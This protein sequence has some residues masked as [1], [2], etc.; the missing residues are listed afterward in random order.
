MATLSPVLYMVQIRVEFFRF[1]LEFQGSLGIFAERRSIHQWNA[2]IFHKDKVKPFV[3]RDCRAS[4]LMDVVKSPYFL[5][6]PL[7]RPVFA[8][9]DHLQ[10][11]TLVVNFRVQGVDPS[12][13]YFLIAK[14]A[15]GERMFRVN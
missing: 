4:Q 14:G 15:S 3:G 5:F 11:Q 1:L 8:R 2:H 9:P 7:F 12:V 6:D 13:V 10:D